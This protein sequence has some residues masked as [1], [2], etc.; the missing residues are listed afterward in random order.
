M[1]TQLQEDVQ[2][3]AFG[4]PLEVGDKV[5]YVFKQASANLTIS[6]ATVVGR[7]DK[8]I[9]IVVSDSRQNGQPVFES[10]EPKLTKPHALVKYRTN[11]AEGN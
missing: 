2:L 4:T 8:R 3:D 10:H 11:A 1:T 6:H 9:K 7:T 5:L